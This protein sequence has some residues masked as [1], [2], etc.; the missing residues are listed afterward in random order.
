VD[1]EENEVGI[2]CVGAPIFDYLTKP[3]GAISI[4]APCDRM[5]NERV[6]SLGLLV[7]QAA[8][9]ISRRKGFTGLISG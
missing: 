8:Q 2:R 3:I 4:S 1:N 6:N 5:D 9:K 7:Q